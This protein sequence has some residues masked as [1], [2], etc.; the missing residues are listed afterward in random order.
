MNKLQV[1]FSAVA[2]LK[3]WP[4]YLADYLKIKN[5]RLIY[6]LRNGSKYII[7]ANSNDRNIFN[8]VLI[9]KIYNP[10]GFEIKKGD[11]VL[12]IGAHVGTFSIFAS[13]IA[14]KVYS[15]EPTQENFKILRENIEL[16][17]RNNIVI[18]NRAVS[19]VN[20]KRELFIDSKNLGGHSFY[21]LLSENKQKRI[22]I[23]T[24]SLKDLFLQNKIQKVD[25]LKMDCEGAEYDILFNCQKEVLDK[26]QKISME[27]HNINKTY[28]INALKNFMENN[29]FVVKV[30][31]ALY[32]VYAT[33]A[34]D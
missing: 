30:L 10:L 9:H 2:K 20:G 7:R 26:I 16:N 6:I 4:V 25:F 28:N 18:D 17:K 31:E 3:N 1:F 8:E 14:S 12:D 19:F 32:M 15:F 24:V 34:N 21:Q 29:G 11:V 5:G 23:E 22:L 33:K 27:Y 13:E